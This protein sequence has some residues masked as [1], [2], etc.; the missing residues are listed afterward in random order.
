[1]PLVLDVHGGPWFRDEW[2]F[3]ADH[4]WLADR[5]YA[6]LSV[7]YR[8]ST[9][10]GKA[11][12]NAADREWAGKM[13]DDLIDAVEWAVREGIAAES[14]GRHHG[15]QLRRLRDAGRAEFHARGVR[16]RRGHRRPVEPG[17][18]A[19]DISAVLG[20]VHASAEVRGSATSSTE[21]GQR[22]CCSARR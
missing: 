1:M 8:G 22:S 10:F 11:F 12:V 19:A 15:R 3:N 13:H 21:E 4:Q 16:L 6:V 17:D 7:N 20:A 2:G 5:G 14:D 9:G 18:A